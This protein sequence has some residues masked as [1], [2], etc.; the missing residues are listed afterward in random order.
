LAISAAVAGVAFYEDPLWMIGEV[1][2]ARLALAGVH[3]AFAKVGE[4]RVHYLVGG[5]GSPLLLIH[6][7]GSRAQ[8]WT[9]QIPEY[10]K[11]GYRVYAIDLL[12]CG[13]TDQPEIEYSIRQQT[14]MVE[15]FLRVAGIEQADVVG[16]SMGGWVALQLALEHPDRVRRIVAMASAGLPFQTDL[17]PEVLEPQTV[18]E[19]ERLAGLL[20]PHPPSL[21]RFFSRALLRAMQRNFPVIRRSVQSMQS[22]KDFLGGR[23]GEIRMPVLLVWG[24]QDALIPPSVGERMHRKM[25]HSVL[26]LYRGCGHLCPATRAGRIVPRVI[27]F[28]KSYP[29][30]AGGT[31]SF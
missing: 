16:W 28:L 13:R 17:T 31:F 11:Q 24:E 10:V 27:E 6:G 2:R 29:A 9:P 3:S 18:A 25:P 26:Q 21:P 15:G 22:G 1:L 20:I 23:L 19:L 30:P 14:E 12:G 5:R 8:D 4:Y 7:L